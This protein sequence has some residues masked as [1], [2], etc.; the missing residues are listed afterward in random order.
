MTDTRRLPA[1]P[2][3]RLPAHVS[4]HWDWQ[5][6]AACRGMD[7]DVFFSAHKEARAPRAR[8]IDAAKAVCAQCPV[9][10]PCRI[11]AL[12]SREP[13]GVWG[14]LSEAERASILG[15][16][17]IQHPARAMVHT[18]RSATTTIKLFTHT[19]KDGTQNG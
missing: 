6:Q 7:S 19:D 1:P 17:R 12:S 14:G 4:D 8:H 3:D 2:T 9:L 13:Y 10:H 11:Y 5:R 18:I 16:K 15:L